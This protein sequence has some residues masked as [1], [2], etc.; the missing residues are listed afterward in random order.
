ML[1]VP[2]PEE[3]PGEPSSQAAEQSSER[4]QRATLVHAAIARLPA[5]EREVI[6]AFY[7]EQTP[8]AHVAALLGLSERVVEG[9]LRRLAGA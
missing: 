7:L 9:R 2:L 4:E 3:E 6:I 1:H 5:S 8:S